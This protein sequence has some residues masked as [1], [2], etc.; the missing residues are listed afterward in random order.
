MQ[1]STSRVERSLTVNRVIPRS[2]LPLRSCPLVTLAFPVQSVSLIVELTSAGR[3]TMKCPHCQRQTSPQ[4]ENCRFCG[5][6]IPPA[7]YLLEELGI[8]EPADLAPSTPRQPVSQARED[9]SYHRMASLGDRF[10][11]FGLDCI[12]LSGIFAIVDAW[13]F[14]RWG[15]VDGAELKLTLAS[16]LVAESLNSAVLFLYL[17]VLEASFGATLGKAMVGIRVVRTMDCNPFS[18]FAIRNLLRIVDG[19]GFYLMGAVIAGCSKI[20]R[21]LGDICANTAVIEEDFG[22]GV[23]IATGLLWVGMIAAAVWFVPRIC[24]SNPAIPSPFLNQVVIRV[25]LSEKSAYFTVATLRAD[26]QLAPGRQ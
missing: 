25:G 14:M 18:A 20:H 24:R 4:S 22:Y 23:K 13:A 26:L 5:A 2:T 21:R 17:W 15:I 9:D 3:S 16:L 12:F 8:L 1:F 11:A 10:I 19:L 7:Q 6:V